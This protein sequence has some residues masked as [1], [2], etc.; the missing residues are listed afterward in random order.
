MYMTVLKCTFESLKNSEY[1]EQM[2]KNFN[3]DQCMH[4]WVTSQFQTKREEEHILYRVIKQTDK[5]F[6]YVQS[7][8]EFPKK[9][10]KKAG[11]ELFREMKIENVENRYVTFDI[12]CSTGSTKGFFKDPEDRKNW[13][14]NKLSPFMTDIRLVEDKTD[15]FYIKDKKTATG[16]YFR[17]IGYITDTEKYINAVHNGIGK[18]KCYGM[19]LMLFR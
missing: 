15:S 19:G 9:N 1:P 17:G 16:A 7:D 2:A 11:L 8:H 10:L 12:L 13:L 5:I 14:L 4:H 3:N 6:L 18:Y